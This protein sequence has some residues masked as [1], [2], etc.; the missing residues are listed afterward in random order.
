LV[1]GPKV[2]KEKK[3][4]DGQAL[5]HN[6]VKIRMTEKGRRRIKN[7]GQE[8]KELERGKRQNSCFI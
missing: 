3:I 6:R 4:K 2:G 8:K 5:K 7:R 1:K